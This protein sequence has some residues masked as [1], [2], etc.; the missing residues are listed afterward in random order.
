MRSGPRHGDAEG[1]TARFRTSGK[2]R[3]GRPRAG[4][5]V[6]AR[7]RGDVIRPIQR[8][9]RRARVQH[10]HAAIHGHARAGGGWARSSASARPLRR[11]QR[12]AGRSASTSST[13]RRVPDPQPRGRRRHRVLGRLRRR[14]RRG[15]VA[16]PHH[17]A[18]GQGP[19][20]ARSTS[21]TPPTTT[22]SSRSTARSPR[23]A[24]AWTSVGGYFD[25][26]GTPNPD[27][28]YECDSWGEPY[29]DA[30]G[31]LSGRVV[32][33]SEPVHCQ[34]GGCDRARARIVHLY[35]FPPRGRHG[36]TL[37]L[38]AALAASGGSPSR[39]CIS[40]IPRRPLA[41]PRGEALRRSGRSA[42]PGAP[43]GP[44]LKRRLFPS[45]LWESGRAR[46]RAIRGHLDR[47]RLG[48]EAVVFLHTTY[49]APLLGTPAVEPRR[50][51][52]DA[53][54]LVWR[55]HANDALLRAGARCV[56]C[57]PPTRRPSARAS[58]ER[59][60]ALTV[61]LAAGHEDYELLRTELR[62]CPLG[63]DADAG[64]TGRAAAGPV[65][66]ELR[67]GLLGNFAHQ[68]T[69]ASAG[70]ADRVEARRRPGGD[71]RARRV[72]TPMPLTGVAPRVEVRG[73]LERVENPSTRDVD[74]IVAPVVGGSGMKVKLAEAVLAGR[75]VVTTPLGAAG[76]PPSV[77]RFFTVCEPAAA[78]L[79]VVRRAI[80]GFDRAGRPRG[81]RA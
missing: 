35:P 43:A 49:L 14:R 66:G 38:R 37:R 27:G 28:L 45:T 81:A 32:Q 10:G 39:S 17:R 1:S 26:D 73:A 51:I 67:V 53:Y 29:D 9:G 6:A 40:S 20:R 76:Y 2:G 64:R 4:S 22:P 71:D 25:A 77:S 44:V 7:R 72:F 18:R 59:S 52:V 42:A 78:R 54:D 50:S 57:A 48:P 60:P 63:A 11:H 62:G 70:S 13:G 12:S 8:D 41:R 75:P 21:T 24:R 31:G 69:R 65:G 16:H 47:A 5:S 33:T 56:L 61:V 80:E 36:G 15:H 23:R 68:S 79:G 46:R 55:A 74:C 30:P 58:A 19:T 3:S 34:A